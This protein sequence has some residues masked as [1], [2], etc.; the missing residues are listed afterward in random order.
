MRDATALVRAYLAPLQLPPHQETK[1]VEELAAQLEESH[2]AL[3]AAGASDEDAWRE[4]RAQL[5]D[6]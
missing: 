6:P 2:D 4:I 3:V 1:I 5:P